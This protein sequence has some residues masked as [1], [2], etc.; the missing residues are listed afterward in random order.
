MPFVYT[1]QEYA[2]IVYVYGLCDGNATAAVLA[3]QARFPNRRIP[4]AQL[5]E[6]TCLYDSSIASE[7]SQAELHCT[8]NI[9]KLSN[10]KRRR[11]L[12]KQ[13]LNC[14]KLISTS[15]DVNGA[16]VKYEGVNTTKHSTDLLSQSMETMSKARYMLPSPYRGQHRTKEG[17][18]EALCVLCV[19]LYGAET[20]TLRRSE[21]KRLEAFQMC[22]WIR[23]EL[24]KWKERIRNEVVL[25]RN[26]KDKVIDHFSAIS[27][28]EPTRTVILSLVLLDQGQ[29]SPAV[30][31]RGATA[32]AFVIPHRD[33][34]HYA[35]GSTGLARVITGQ[36]IEMHTNSECIHMLELESEL[37]L[38]H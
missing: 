5:E 37:S 18:S 32:P 15:Q 22:L 25:E 11:R 7:P 3:Y 30:Q 1:H 12:L 27:R 8:T 19:A 31:S 26:I 4:S 13:F 28:L 10:V 6:E 35:V 17:T 16:Y 14:E 34:S 2:D 36:S 29:W 33:S 38:M 9:L 23:M 20:W 21:E 24:V